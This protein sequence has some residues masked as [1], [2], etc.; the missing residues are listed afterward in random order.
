M[1][2][3]WCAMEKEWLPNKCDYFV[4]WTEENKTK[5]GW[6]SSHYWIWIYWKCLWTLKIDKIVSHWQVCFI[7]VQSVHCKP[8]QGVQIHTFCVQLYCL[9]AVFIMIKQN[10]EFFETTNFTIQT[11]THCRPLAKIKLYIYWQSTFNIYQQL[12]WMLWISMSYAHTKFVWLA[13]W[14]L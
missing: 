8:Y 4:L 2:R 10:W 11:A 12:N 7:V 9:L 1:Y 6:K 5:A 14:L 3:H 13:S